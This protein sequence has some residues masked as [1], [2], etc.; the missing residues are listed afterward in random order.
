ML[1]RF[2]GSGRDILRSGIGFRN[3]PV[4]TGKEH[5]GLACRG[6]GYP[7]NGADEREDCLLAN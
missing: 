6:K 1:P 5:P 7:K 2:V 4:E 3:R